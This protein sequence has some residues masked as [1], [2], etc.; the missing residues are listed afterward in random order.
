MANV[1]YSQKIVD[2]CEQLIAARGL[3]EHGGMKIVNYCKEVGINEKTHRNWL[4]GHKAYRE[5][6]ERGKETYKSTH[7]RKLFNTL[8]DA[9][10]GGEHTVEEEHTDYVPNPDD[11]TQPRIRK[12]TKTKKKIYL[13]PDV[14]AAIFLLCN[15]DPEHYQ[16]RQKNDV[17]IKKAEPEEEMSMDEIN[18][19]IERLKALEK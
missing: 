11:P 3:V 6:V 5:A 8:M 7:T 10:L 15:L 17:S 9:A 1:K 13:R 16:N 12:M 4:K 2:E 18:A 14:G 19:E